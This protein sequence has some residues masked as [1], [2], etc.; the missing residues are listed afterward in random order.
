MI[1]DKFIQD[2][3]SESA[4][5]LKRYDKTFWLLHFWDTVYIILWQ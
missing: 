4:K 1:W 5:V 3:S 2:T